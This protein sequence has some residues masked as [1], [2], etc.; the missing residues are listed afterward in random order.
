MELVNANDVSAKNFFSETTQGELVIAEIQTTTMKEEKSENDN[1][2]AKKEEIENKKVIA[3][4]INY[5]SLISQ[6]TTPMTFFIELGTVTR[7]P[8]FLEDVAKLVKKDAKIELTILDTVNKE[9][10]TQEEAYINHQILSN[11]TSQTLE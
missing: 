10:S 9:T 4:T 3:R 6:Y 8:E 1:V 11:Y 7:N 5:K 2:V